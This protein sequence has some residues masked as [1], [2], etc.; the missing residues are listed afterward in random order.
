MQ[1]MLE[2]CGM[3]LVAD[4][5]AAVLELVSECLS[6][7]GYETCAA[8]SGDEAIALA[9][10]HLI[11]AAV[12]D[13]NLPGRSGYEVCRELRRLYGTTIPIL[14]V[15]GDRT[16]SYDRVGGLLLGADDYLVK[17]LDPDD[18]V[19]RL[20]SAVVRA[21]SETQERSLTPRELEILTLLTDGLAQREIAH[22]L[23][24][25]SNTVATHIERILRKLGVRSRA[26]AVALAF[27]ETLVSVS[28]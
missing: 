1:S 6:E 16:E 10:Q 20:G 7:A 9:V 28:A 3:V 19:A 8:K 23:G 27:R 22:R 14:F 24:I 26:Q 11:G 25:T 4:D 18:L 5:D 17:P 15:S 21:R 2:L 13:V 12:L